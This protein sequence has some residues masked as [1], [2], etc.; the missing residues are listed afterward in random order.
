VIRLG[1]KDEWVDFSQWHDHQDED[2][3]DDSGDESNK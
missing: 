1:V 2:D 3:D